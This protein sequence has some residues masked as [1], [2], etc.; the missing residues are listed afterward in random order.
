MI[1]VSEIS[2][3]PR[4]ANNVLYPGEMEKKVFKHCLMQ[5]KVAYPGMECNSLLEQEPCAKGEWLVLTKEF[6]KYGLP[7]TKC[8]VG[9]FTLFLFL[10]YF[11]CKL[12]YSKI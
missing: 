3:I 7:K 6:D 2:S 10:N 11:I 5:N 1:L 9:H 12:S 8:N 4:P